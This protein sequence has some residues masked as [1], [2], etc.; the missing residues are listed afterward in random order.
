MFRGA[1]ACFPFFRSAHG[2]HAHTCNSRW[3]NELRTSL[4]ASMNQKNSPLECEA[5]NA[6]GQYVKGSQTTL[7]LLALCMSWIEFHTI[8]WSTNRR[9]PVSI[10]ELSTA[11]KCTAVKNTPVQF[12]TSSKLSSLSLSGRDAVVHERRGRG[13]NLHFFGPVEGIEPN[14]V[15]SSYIHRQS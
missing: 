10:K 14:S 5:E 7:F 6:S 11:G 15:P 8:L 3:H 12:C 9:S 1:T 2:D 13:A 4:R